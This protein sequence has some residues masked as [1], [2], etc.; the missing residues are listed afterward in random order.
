MVFVSLLIQYGNRH[1]RREFFL[2]GMIR[3][4][5]IVLACLIIQA[6]TAVVL[7]NTGKTD[8]KSIK[9]A[10]YQDAIPVGFLANRELNEVS[11]LACSRLDNDVLWAINDSGSGPLLYAVST[12]GANLDTVGVV[13]AQNR[14]WEDLA[15]FRLNDTAYLLIADV[16]DNAET[17]ADYSIYI[18]RE[19]VIAEG[20]LSANRT[21]V[22]EARIRFIYEDGSH[23]CE[24]VAVDLSSRQIFLLSKRDVPPA[25]YAMPLVMQT[26]DSFQVA[27]RLASISLI[28][29]PTFKDIMEDP[30]FGPYRAQPT[31]MDVSP[32]GLKAVV[33]TYKN[34][35]LFQRTPEE[36]WADA[37]KK[38]PQMMQLPKLRQAEALCFAADARTLFITSEK[39]PAPLLRLDLT[40][41]SAS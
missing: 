28:P 39:H 31:A 14:D 22:L 3:Y 40:H 41:G 16:G 20:S 33:L 18:I 11:G 23:D 37:F 36:N 2:K 7:E 5:N 13:G 8:A 4:G 19:P 38:P 25:L 10:A 12:N 35:Y 29:Q 15:S 24:S 34:A 30:K 27:R 26:G 6:C 17:R 1:P 32:D 21:A 9:P